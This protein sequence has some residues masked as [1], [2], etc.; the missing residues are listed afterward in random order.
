MQIP[1]LW[2]RPLQSC[3]DD[4]NTF[5]NLGGV[6]TTTRVADTYMCLPH[7]ST[8]TFLSVLCV[9]PHLFIFPHLILV[10]APWGGQRRHRNELTFLGSN[11]QIWHPGGMAQVCARPRL[12]T[13]GGRWL[14]SSS[15]PLRPQCSGQNLLEQVMD[16]FIQ[17][18]SAFR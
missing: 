12:Y 14:C 1:R 16:A 9:C 11:R 2:L 8:D 6:P 10:T 17:C 4:S 13:A 15:L 7:V 3:S 5:G 18:P